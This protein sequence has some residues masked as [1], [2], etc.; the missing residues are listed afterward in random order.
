MD[1]LRLRLVEAEEGET[2]AH[3]LAR[4]EN[5]WDVATTSAFNALPIDA[6]LPGKMLIKIARREAYLHPPGSESPATLPKE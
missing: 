5:A 2:L 4:T 3:L 1:V 6:V